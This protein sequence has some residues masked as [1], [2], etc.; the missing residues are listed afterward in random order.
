MDFMRRT[1]GPVLRWYRIR[2]EP[3][4]VGEPIEVIRG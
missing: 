2:V 3:P 4:A 1:P